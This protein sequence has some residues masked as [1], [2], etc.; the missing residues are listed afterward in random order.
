MSE[1]D[2]ETA[3]LIQFPKIECKG[4]LS[5]WLIFS[6]NLPAETA[7]AASYLLVTKDHLYDTAT[8]LHESISTAF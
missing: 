6:A 4:S 7:V 5:F 3:P 8:S 1:N 2:A